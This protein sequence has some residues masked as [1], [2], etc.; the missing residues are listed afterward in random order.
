MHILSEALTLIYYYY[1]VYLFLI[2]GF[3]LCL[4][5]FLRFRRKQGH[6]FG[7]LKV[8]I[9]FMILFTL[10]GFSSNYYAKL[11]L[12]PL[13]YHVTVHSDREFKNIVDVA[14]VSGIKFP[15]TVI[16]DKKFTNEETK[17]YVLS[18]PQGHARKVH[19][20]RSENRGIVSVFYAY[21]GKQ[22]A[23]E[24]DL[25]G[26]KYAEGYSLPSNSTAE[27]LLDL[28]I[29][30]CLHFVTLILCSLLALHLSA[31]NSLLQ[32]LKPFLIRN[33]YGILCF[34]LL[35]IHLLANRQQYVVAW[36]ASSYGLHYGL[37]FA[38]RFM[39]GSILKLLSGA[40][41]SHNEANLFLLFH[42]TLLC[43]ALSYCIN[44]IIISSKHSKLVIF[45]CL[46]Y[47]LNPGG[48]TAMWNYVNY[49]RLETYNLLY[50][51][52]SLI[53]FLKIKKVFL[54][55]TLITILSLFNM[56]IYQGF[57]FLYY[58]AV[59]LIMIADCYQHKA[60]KIRWALTLTNILLITASFFVFQ[61]VSNIVFS[62]V[63]EMTYYLNENTSLKYNPEPLRLEYF[64]P[65]SKSYLT[66]KESIIS[67][68]SYR[69]NTFLSIL[70]ISPV[71]LSILSL[72]YFCLRKQN[73]RSA[74]SSPYLAAISALLLFLPQFI[75]NVDWGRWAIAMTFYGFF[76]TLYLYHMGF[77]QM[78]NAFEKAESYLIKYPFFAIMLIGYIA[79]L[80]RFGDIGL[81]SEAESILS[82]IIHP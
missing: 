25:G 11:E 66:V 71:I 7:I 23:E 29:R 50:T 39:V 54:K 35:F 79:I 15:P 5:L 69:Q 44:F 47:L 12:K 34:L 14:E 81:L 31:H 78:Q 64:S 70:L 26:R 80:S 1:Q 18:I 62:N 37:G 53:I 22:Y 38:S 55:Y 51:L 67:S 6:S 42:L 73:P 48:I 49:G 28:L 41:V 9:V 46:L 59:F 10:C 57:V 3:L 21:D 74:L 75:F 27:M 36:A 65:F 16:T 52:L 77:P 82:D 2:P 72:W 43:G 30:L 4:F 13:K 40:Y 24:I 8:C 76:A 32:R 45:L 61:F 56:A 20:Y 33:Q 63:N 60:D 68:Y 19:F 58:P 17:E